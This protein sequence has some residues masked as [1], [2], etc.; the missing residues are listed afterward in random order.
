M[1]PIGLEVYGAVVLRGPRG[2]KSI[3][4]F[5]N[6][7]QGGGA[8]QPRALHLGLRAAVPVE[9]VPDAHHASR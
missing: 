9:P 2:M 3:I 5:T 6:T 4:R 7:V 1:D 8:K